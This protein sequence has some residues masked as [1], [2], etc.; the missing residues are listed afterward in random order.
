MS[1]AASAARATPRL[2]DPG[3]DTAGW[4]DWIGGTAADHLRTALRSGAPAHAYLISGAR[5]VGKHR[6]ALAFCQAI[7]CSNPVQDDPSLP[8]GT[9][10]ECRNVA[11]RAHPDVEW[12]GL[13]EQAMLSDKG[14][15]SSNLSIETIRR[16]RGAAAMLPLEAPQRILI[17]DDAESM[18]PTAQQA[19]LKTL[20]E[21]PPS[22]IMVLLAAEAE[23]LLETV[24]SRCQRLEVTTVPEP[25]VATT[26]HALGADNEVASEIAEF[27]RGRM[28]W[29]I[30]AFRAP[31]LLDASRQD[32]AMSETWLRQSR[33]EQL[34]TAYHLGERFTKHRDEVIS[35][36][37]MVVQLLRGELLHAAGQSAEATA[38]DTPQTLTARELARAIAATLRCLADLDAN[39]RPRLTLE[40]MV[41]SW[42]DLSHK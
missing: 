21:P 9:C 4:P 7:C 12:Y 41:M 30:E 40:T 15:P 25:R 31:E 29:A 10:R 3:L 39:A 13:A 14:T 32:R 37:Q 23:S 19:L 28:A 33:Y 42:P 20:E 17:V 22:V 38:R 5:G 26:L 35:T 1:P 24:R 27:S 36:V 11:R 18:L 6:L 2:A 34:I 16:L 8:C